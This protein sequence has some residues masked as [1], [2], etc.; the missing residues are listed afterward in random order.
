MMEVVS[1]IVL[2]VVLMFV[3]VFVWERS[4]RT[5]GLLLDFVWSEVKRYG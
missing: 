2:P 1:L 4:L 5:I 3:L